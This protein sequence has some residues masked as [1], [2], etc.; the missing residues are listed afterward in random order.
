MEYKTTEKIPA[1][2]V[3]YLEYG[4][5]ASYDMTDDEIKELDT[6]IKDNFPYGYI[7]EYH[8]DNPYFS[9]YPLFGLPCDVYDVDFYAA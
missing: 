8:L 7:C 1:H 3:C 5:E 6:W 4:S 2:M 9:R